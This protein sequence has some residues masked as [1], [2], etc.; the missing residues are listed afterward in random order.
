MLQP[1]QYLYV[2]FRVAV[3]R[4]RQANWER[5]I[6]FVAGY[7]GIPPNRVEE[8]LRPIIQVGPA[9]SVPRQF[10]TGSY[11]AFLV[12]RLAERAGLRVIWQSIP[13]DRFT[14]HNPEKRG[15]VELRIYQGAGRSG[16]PK[17]KPLRLR[18]INEQSHGLPLRDIRVNG[19]CE[20]VGL[21]EFHLERW[22]ELGYYGEIIDYGQI[23]CALAQAAE[24]PNAEWY[25]PVY[26]ALSS[27]GVVVVDN[28]D[29]S[30]VR[31]MHGMLWESFQQVRAAELQP[32]VVLLPDEPELSWT[33][34]HATTPA[35]GKLLELVDRI[36]GR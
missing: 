20:P 27:A 14:V 24:L 6:K 33:A 15:L 36:S 23:Y 18:V 13:Q 5:V 21:L 4:A 32:N 2:H 35:P 8:I 11:E 31:P 28:Y 26:L 9:V 29:V 19:T 30:Y 25:Y 3:E 10:V 22:R 17:L 7:T 12:C 1:D 16:G 34:E